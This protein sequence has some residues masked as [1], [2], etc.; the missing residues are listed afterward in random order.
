MEEK[1]LLLVSIVKTDGGYITEIT[2]TDKGTGV[3]INKDRTTSVVN[4]VK[5]FMYG[6]NKPPKKH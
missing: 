3:G 1:H 4:A 6:L 2:T 5:S